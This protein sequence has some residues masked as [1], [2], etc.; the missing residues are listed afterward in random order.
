MDLPFFENDI[1]TSEPNSKLKIN[2]RTQ[3]V[4]SGCDIVLWYH[5]KNQAT[6]SFI[7]LQV[8]KLSI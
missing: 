1:T 6:D 3:K 5:K 4:S 2:S 8:S 7:S